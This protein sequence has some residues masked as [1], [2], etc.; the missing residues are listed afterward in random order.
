MEHRQGSNTGA[1]E[2][3]EGSMARGGARKI[4][5]SIGLN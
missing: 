3:D 1:I 5:L 4:A 2:G